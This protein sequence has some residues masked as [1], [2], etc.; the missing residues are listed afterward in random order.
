MKITC[1]R[2]RAVE[3][4]DV[5]MVVYQGETL[6]ETY[7]KRGIASEI[8]RLGRRKHEITRNY[9]ILPRNTP[10]WCR[11]GS[12]QGLWRC[13]WQ[14]CLTSKCFPAWSEAG[15][16]ISARLS[17]IGYCSWREALA[18]ASYVQPLGNQEVC[19]YAIVRLVHRGN[20]RKEIPDRLL[21]L[22]PSL[23]SRI[24]PQLR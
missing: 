6:R 7:D 9:P 8:P 4:N 14:V 21:F 23:F 24:V 18:N 16:L 3:N 17:R 22:F 20:E 13:T 11:P 12:S 10:T 19:H 1:D 15:G 5:G 2:W